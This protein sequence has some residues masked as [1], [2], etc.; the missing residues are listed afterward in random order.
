MRSILKALL[1][2]AAIAACYWC[3]FSAYRDYSLLMMDDGDGHARFIKVKSPKKSKAA[4][5]AAEP[6]EGETPQAATN[7][8]PVKRPA[9]VVTAP[10]AGEGEDDAPT[11][12]STPHV[13]RLYM[14]ILAHTVGF[15]VALVVI[16]LVAAHD[17]GH[18]LKF[19]LGKEVS[20]VND[21]AARN[22]AYEHAEDVVLKGQTG[23]A[24]G[25]LKESVRQHPTHIHS[26]LRIA[27]LY[28]KELNDFKNAAQYYEELLKQKL[29]AE[30]WGWV[31]IRLANI[32]SGKL[33]R[34]DA[35][36]TLIKR[37]VAT[38]PQTQ[39][40]AK[41]RRR[42][43]QIDRTGLDSGAGKDV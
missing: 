41:A 9:A 4:A 23:E 14:H 25:L 31:A 24:I 11:T 32:Y 42:L 27:E 43:A 17:F 36:I 26:I 5:V 34:P 3:G 7:T 33:G 35:A 1:Y 15:G 10:A 12:G 37:L 38:H 21:R 22:A 6:A 20:Y 16:G 28:D 30:Q 40:A 19:K 13:G 18:L 39:A 2:V 29:P 8:P